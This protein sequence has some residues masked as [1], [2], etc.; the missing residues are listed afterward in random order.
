MPA[1][2]RP[3]HVLP[4]SIAGCFDASNPAGKNAWF[5][6][7]C[8][9]CVSTFLLLSCSSLHGLGACKKIQFSQSS[10]LPTSINCYFH[11]RASLPPL[12]PASCLLSSAHILGGYLTQGF[13]CRCWGI[14]RLPSIAGSREARNECHIYLGAIVRRA[15]EQQFL[16]SCTIYQWMFYWFWIPARVDPHYLPPVKLDLLQSRTI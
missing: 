2:L 10:L 3:L 9:F 6:R 16:P 5:R 12:V 15:H 1:L 8:V 4:G 11:A 13:S 14:M 7:V